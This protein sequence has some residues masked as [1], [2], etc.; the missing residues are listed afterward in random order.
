MLRPH[1]EKAG[2][3]RH[4]ST[5]PTCFN[6]L[7]GQQFRHAIPKKIDDATP[8]FPTFSSHAFRVFFLLPRLR[9]HQKTIFAGVLVLEAIAT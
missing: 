8:A 6:Q 9:R 3:Q 7:L 1:M 5:I 4:V 2:W